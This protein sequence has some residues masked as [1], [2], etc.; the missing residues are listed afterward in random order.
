MLVTLPPTPQRPTAQLCRLAAFHYDSFRLFDVLRPRAPWPFLFEFFVWTNSGLSY[1]VS[2]RSVSFRFVSFRCTRVSPPCVR[3]RRRNP[4]LHTRT[5]ALTL[6]TFR[7]VTLPTFAVRKHE[8]KIFRSFM[9]NTKNSLNLMSFSNKWLFI[10]ILK[11]PL[12]SRFKNK[13]SIDLLF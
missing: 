10:G 1:S 4:S 2:F 13:V 11:F 12:V 7:H 5:A 9:T 6:D 3:V 8:L